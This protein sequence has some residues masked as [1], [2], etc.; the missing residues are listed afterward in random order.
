MSD[1]QLIKQLSELRSLKQSPALWREQTRERILNSIKVEPARAKWNFSESFALRFSTLRLQ[2]APLP[3][4]PTLM[5]ILIVLFGSVPFVQATGASLPS[6]PLYGLK[7]LSEQVQLSLVSS[8][9]KQ[10]FTYL[11][12]ARTRLG[13]LQ[14]VAPTDS[15]V[16]ARLLV[17]YNRSL[18]FAQ[19]DLQAT[20]TTSKQAAEY[21]AISSTLSDSIRKLEINTLA[22][23]PYTASL[24]LTDRLASDALA[25]LVATHGGNQNGTTPTA[26]AARFDSQIDRIGLK[27]DGIET[28]L[29]RLPINKVSPRVVLES[30]EA[31][32]PARE[33]S[34]QAKQALA[35]AK[36]LVQK[37]EFTLA[38]QKVQ[39]VEEITSKTEAAVDKVENS[40]EVK[41]T[42][43]EV[44][45]S[46]SQEGT[47]SGSDEVKKSESQN[48][49]TDVTP[50]IIK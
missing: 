37:K 40:G 1:R 12:I 47:K 13:E 22:R 41:G 17:D 46:E 4:M 20:I 8:P 19:A 25:M 42:Q 48:V 23:L 24:Q 35:Q 18:S 26:V 9:E 38:L 50:E 45:K 16:Q 28:K 29:D 15:A 10:G 44:K 36:E 43:D 33:A 5:T 2:F 11:K 49:N 30:R 3:V 7:R 14:K 27:L 6:S 32:L 34:R 31:V 21:D 39:E